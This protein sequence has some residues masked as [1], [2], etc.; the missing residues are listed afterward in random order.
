M[1]NLVNFIQSALVAIAIGFAAYL[2]AFVIGI[3]VRKALV[4]FL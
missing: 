4:R 1:D 2:V 3:V